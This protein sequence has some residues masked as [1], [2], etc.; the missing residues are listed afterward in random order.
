MA[1]KYAVRWKP[2]INRSSLET[3]IQNRDMSADPPNS[4]NRVRCLQLVAFDDSQVGVSGNAYVP[5]AP[6]TEQFITIIDERVVT[7]GIA[8]FTGLTFAQSQALWDAERDAWIARW[9]SSPDLSGLLNSAIGAA[10]STYR[11]IA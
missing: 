8:A 2:D 9:Q 5:G 7:L 1:V 10:L 3:K 6:A 4:G 11:I